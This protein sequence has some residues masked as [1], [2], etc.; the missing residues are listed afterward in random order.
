[1]DTYQLSDKRLAVDKRLVSDKPPAV[2]DRRLAVVEN[3]LVA[4]LPAALPRILHYSP[5]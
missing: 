2:V 5:R 3:A 1:M 4:R